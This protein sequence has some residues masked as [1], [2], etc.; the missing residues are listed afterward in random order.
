MIPLVSAGRKTDTSTEEFA[1]Y[2]FKFVLSQSRRDA[3]E[4]DVSQLMRFDGFVH[5]ELENSY[6]VR[7]LY[8]DNEIA[9]NYYEKIDGVRFRQKFRIRT[10][11]Q[12]PDPAL[13]IFLEEK[14][15]Y[16]ERTFKRRVAIDVDHLDIFCDPNRHFE[17]LD[18]YPGVDLIERLVFSSAR[19]LVRPR[20]LVDYVRRPY[21]SDFDMNFRVTF[22]SQLRAAATDIIFPNESAYWRMCDA[23]Y[24]I[25]E[26]KFHRRVP[27]WFH[28]VLQSHN[29]RR[30]SISKF[31]RGMEVCGLAKDLS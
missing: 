20:V 24:T 28:R 29:L 31:C 27:A 14:G 8:F 2:E 3:L 12:S 10:Y 6:L 30:L 4:D 15:R 5:P 19:K 25:V 17:L 18:L 11:G 22:D 16:I 1:R 7:S 9:S 23:G 26:V 21:V 13:P